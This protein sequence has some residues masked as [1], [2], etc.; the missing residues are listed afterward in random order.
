[1]F[2]PLLDSQYGK[3][4][5][6]SR[7]RPARFAKS[8]LYICLRS[9]ET[10]NSPFRIRLATG[11]TS[12]M[13]SAA[14]DYVKAYGTNALANGLSVGVPNVRICVPAVVRWMYHVALLGRNTAVGVGLDEVP[15]L[16]SCNAPAAMVVPPA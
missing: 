1:M 12:Q 14:D 13:V 7:L 5:A 8:F 3:V 15:P 4:C 9:H 11:F 2:E 16:P 6:K 10:G